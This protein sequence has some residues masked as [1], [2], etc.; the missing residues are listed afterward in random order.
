M[1]NALEAIQHA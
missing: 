1:R